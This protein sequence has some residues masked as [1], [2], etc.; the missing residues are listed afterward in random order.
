M[1]KIKIEIDLAVSDVPE[2]GFESKAGAV[3]FLRERV[4]G[5]AENYDIE[6]GFYIVDILGS[7]VLFD[8]YRTFHSWTVDNMAI[9]EGVASFHTH[10]T[11]SSLTSSSF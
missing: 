10:Q 8:T 5:I 4:Q 1:A 6:I 2:G 3:Q 11:S 9:R 7:F